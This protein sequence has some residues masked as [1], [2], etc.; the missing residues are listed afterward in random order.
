L[1]ITVITINYLIYLFGLPLQATERGHPEN[2]GSL[3]STPSPQQQGLGVLLSLPA[4]C[5]GFLAASVDSAA[6]IPN[7]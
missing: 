6:P 7:G 2:D 4:D 1:V 3:R 5:R